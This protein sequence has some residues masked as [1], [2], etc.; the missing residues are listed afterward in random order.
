MDLADEQRRTAWKADLAGMF[1]GRKVVTGLLPLAALTPW[2]ALLKDAGAQRPLVLATGV[3]VGALPSSDDAEIVVLEQPRY[4]SMTEELRRSDRFARR[5]PPEARAALARYDPDR[6]AVWWHG[7]FVVDQP[8]DGRP[9][10]G[11]RPAA[12][13]ALEDK[14]LAEGIWAAVGAPHAPTR[15]LPVDARTLREASTALDQG[16]GVVWATRPAIL[17]ARP[18]GPAWAT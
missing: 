5:L 13:L 14:L 4:P 18:F 7:P 2:V 11:G 9:V 6:E 1:R 10:L 16:A 17:P 12:W 8:I 3:G 15:V